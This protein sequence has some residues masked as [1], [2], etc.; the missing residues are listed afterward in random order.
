VNWQTVSPLLTVCV[1]EKE[2]FI[3]NHQVTESR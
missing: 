1:R 3:D 2:E